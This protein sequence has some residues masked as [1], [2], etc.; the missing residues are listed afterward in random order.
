MSLSLDK[1]HK[2]TEDQE[3]IPRL[4]QDGN[5]TVSIPWRRILQLID[6]IQLSSALHKIEPV[7]TEKADTL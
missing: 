7:L 1:R 2:L 6:L 4:P 3:T 5:D